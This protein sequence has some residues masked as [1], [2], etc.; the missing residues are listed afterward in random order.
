MNKQ[1]SFGI[2]SPLPAGQG[3]ASQVGAHGTHLLLL[4]LFVA[5][6]LVTR[7]VLWLPTQRDLDFSAY[8]AAGQLAF[9][10]EG[11]P[12]DWRTLTRLGREWLPERTPVPGFIYT[13]VALLAFGVFKGLEFTTAAG[14]MLLV[15]ILTAA[16]AFA[17][18]ARTLE[19][20]SS[21]RMFLCWAGYTLCFAPLYESLG[22]G[23]VNPVLLLLLCAVWSAYRSNRAMWAGG[24]AA[25]AAVFLKFHFGLLLLPVLL[26]RQWRLALWGIAFLSLGV[27]LSAALLPFDA[28]AQWHEHVVS[29]SSLIRMPRG[30]PGV[31]DQSNLSLPGLTGRFLLK[32]LAFPN[33]STPRE[34]ASLV[35]T[36]L[37][38]VLACVMAWVLWRSSRMPRTPE[39]AD[40]E[41]CLVLATAFEVSPIS[42]G[43]HLMFLLPV[44][45]L[46]GRDVVLTPGAPAP[47][48]VLLGTLILILALHPYFLRLH[49]ATVILVVATVRALVT[50]TVW[51]AMAL[52]LL[53][54]SPAPALHTPAFHSTP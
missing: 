15:N 1:S 9:S 3:A 27:G 23:Q 34:L 42:W 54:L 31:A 41:V 48:R 26:R 36:S 21:R 51:S 28:W 45:Y 43:P 37:C 5:V 47:Q 6:T 40:M 44:V 20:R 38:V 13:P 11:A 18:L 52:L 4:V 7:E 17:F 2:T 39:R 35:A 22:L 19:L 24:L 12:Y 33:N 49:D 50:L 29:G 8:W 46:L 14:I 25:A 32:N 10:P 53:R 16:A 30:L